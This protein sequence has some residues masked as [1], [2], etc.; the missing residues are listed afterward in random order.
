MPRHQKGDLDYN[1]LDC[2]LEATD[3]SSLILS[4]SQVKGEDFLR[5]NMK[6]FGGGISFTNYMNRI[7][8]LIGTENISLPTTIR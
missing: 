3:C 7:I 8:R 4:L 5:H 1:I 6:K 2:L